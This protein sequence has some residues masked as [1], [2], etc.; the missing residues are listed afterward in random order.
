MKSRLDYIAVRN[1]VGDIL[2]L[3]EYVED[4]E[5]LR[6]LATQI[7]EDCRYIEIEEDQLPE[8]ETVKKWIKQVY[9]DLYE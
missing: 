7:L 8:L 6:I 9:E 5:L 2:E 4:Q 1:Y 3:K